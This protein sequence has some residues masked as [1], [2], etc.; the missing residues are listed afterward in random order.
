[1]IRCLEDIAR[2]YGIFSHLGFVVLGVRPLPTLLVPS[3]GVRQLAASLRCELL[4]EP[5]ARGRW[6]RSRSCGGLFGGVWR[7]PTLCR[8]W[9]ASDPGRLRPGPWFRPEGVQRLRRSRAG[10]EDAFCEAV[11]KGSSGALDDGGAPPDT[12]RT[13]PEA[14]PSQDSSAF[15]SQ[16]PPSDPY[17]VAAGSLKVYCPVGHVVSGRGRP[18]GVLRLLHSC[19]ARGSAT[20]EK[21]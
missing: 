14:E 21:I 13:I 1:V 2:L 8:G 16:A 4:P 9:P 12:E 6:G 11:L 19:A 15:C 10:P 5:V 3:V 7:P 18:A 20:A 17:L